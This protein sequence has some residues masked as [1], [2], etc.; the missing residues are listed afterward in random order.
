MPALSVAFERSLSGPADQ[1]VERLAHH[2]LRGEQWELGGGAI[3]ARPETRRR[4]SALPRSG[5]LFEQALERA[6]PRPPRAVHHP[7]EQAFDIRSTPR[8]RWSINLETFGGRLNALAKPRAPL[9]QL[10]DDPDVAGRLAS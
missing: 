3:C 2:A 9:E 7:C 8:A 10:N 4:A 6:R 1:H 5:G